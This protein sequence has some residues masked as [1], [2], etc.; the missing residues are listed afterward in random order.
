MPFHKTHSLRCIMEKQTTV[1]IQEFIPFRDT[2]IGLKARSETFVITESKSVELL[3]PVVAPFKA[4]SQTPRL[5][6]LWVRI[7]L[8]AW[9]SVGVLCV[10][11]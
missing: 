7:P 3:N 9:G 11:R 8:G 4:R 2:T 10:V 1:S 5:P 6:G